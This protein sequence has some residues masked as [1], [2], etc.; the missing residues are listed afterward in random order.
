MK[1][2]D[3]FGLLDTFLEKDFI[4]NFIVDSIKSIIKRA[5]AERMINLFDIFFEDNYNTKIEIQP[6]LMNILKSKGTDLTIFFIGDSTRKGLNF[7][8]QNNSD[9][10]QLGN[11]QQET[12]ETNFIEYFIDFQLNHQHNLNTRRNPDQLGCPNTVTIPFD[13]INKFEETKFSH[14]EIITS[15]Y[16]LVGSSNS[17]RDNRV[18]VILKY[19]AKSGD[20]N[21]DMF[22]DT[23]DPRP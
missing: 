17:K 12:K 21:D 20:P 5:D 13:D 1:R 4:S 23:F 19:V 3:L 10:F 8:Y 18:S 15:V 7:V 14:A 11:V 2:E 6:S 9:Y 16:D 22:F